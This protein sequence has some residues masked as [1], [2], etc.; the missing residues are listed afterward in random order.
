MRKKIP[1]DCCAQA[2]QVVRYSGSF[3]CLNVACVVLYFLLSIYWLGGWDS[4][5]ARVSP[6]NV[7][8][9]MVTSFR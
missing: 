4:G 3:I 6:Q 7:H 8:N 5:V 1:Q 2:A 9:I